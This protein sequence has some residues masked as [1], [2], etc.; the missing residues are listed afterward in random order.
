MEQQLAPTVRYEPCAAFVADQEAQ[1]GIC[2][3]GWAED[4]HPEPETASVVAVQFR[5][6]PLRRAS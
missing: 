3:C 1:W 4:E 6:P 5:P 2:Q